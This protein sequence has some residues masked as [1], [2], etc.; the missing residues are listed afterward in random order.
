[1]AALSIQQAMESRLVL[2]DELI[3]QLGARYRA[4]P[5]FLRKRLTFERYVVYRVSNGTVVQ[6]ISSPR[7][8]RRSAARHFSREAM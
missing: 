7:V 1:M 6:K 4:L 5:A 2:P 3:N 8:H